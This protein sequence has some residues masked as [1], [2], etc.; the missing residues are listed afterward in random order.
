VE[1]LDTALQQ[2]LTGLEYFKADNA[3]LR[4]S[5]IYILNAGQALRGE[6]EASGR[7][8]VA[9]DVGA[10][11]HALLRFL[12]TPERSV[13]GEIEAIMDRLS[14]AL[15]FSHDLPLLV[16]HG[17]L[18]VD[19]LP[20]VDAELRHLVDAPTITYARALR[21]EAL[22]YYGQVEARAQIFRWLL[23]LVAVTLVGHLGVLFARLRKHARKLARHMGACA[24][25]WPNGSRQKWLCGPVRNAFVPLRKRP[26]RPLF[27]LTRP[28][29]SSLGTAGPQRSSA[30]RQGKC[31]A[32]QRLSSSPTDI[33]RRTCTCWLS[34]RAAMARTYRAQ[35]LNGPA[36]GKMAASSRSKCHSPPE[37]PLKAS[38]RRA[39]ST[40]SPLANAWKS[41]PGN[42]NSSSFKLTR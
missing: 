15:P 33:R 34:G 21:E 1:A 32:R 10:L 22:R 28:G 30:M 23:Y 14:P 38:T 2:K 11:S 3:L 20:Q 9:A 37:S 18:I 42:R 40:T 35:P 19:V 27:R 6:A 12:Q 5:L 29:P 8:T 41:R 25:R 24:G 13:G 16:A 26:T 7:E 4:N 36:D 17:R 39:S 31:S